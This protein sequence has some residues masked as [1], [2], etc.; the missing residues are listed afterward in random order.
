MVPVDLPLG[1]PT[2][3]LD[4]LVLAELPLGTPTVDLDPPVLVEVLLGTPTVD[5]GTMRYETMSEVIILMM[6]M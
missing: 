1:T 2:V 3:D 6:K 5:L 4:P